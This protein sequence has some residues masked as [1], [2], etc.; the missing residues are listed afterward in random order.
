MIQ[1]AW[2]IVLV[3]TGT[4]A[5]LL[6]YVVSADWIFFGLAAKLVGGD[7]VH[8]DATLI[9][10]DVSWNSLAVQ[11]ADAVGEANDAPPDDPGDPP[12]PSGK[13]PGKTVKS[14]KTAKP[15]KGKKLSRTDPDARM[16]TNK[17]NQRLEPSFKQL[18]GVD[19]RCGIN[20]DV[21][22]VRAD[23][24]EGA[25]LHGQIERVEALTG[26]EVETVTADMAYGS[27]ANF[28]TA[29]A[30]GLYTVIPTQRTRPARVPLSRFRYDA[31]HDVLRA[32]RTQRGRPGMVQRRLDGASFR[33]GSENMEAGKHSDEPVQT[34]FGW[35]VILLE[36][37]RTMEPPTFES[38]K[39]QLAQQAQR[40][41]LTAYLQELRE[42]A[43]IEIK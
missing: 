1:A 32:F 10:A 13:A 6:D 11:Y 31:K 8:V 21:A 4:Y 18:T 33:R 16:A 38:V 34:Q 19:S 20:V 41:A 24:H 12:P 9:R 22:V 43:E 42:S 27:A 23:I 39:P 5:Q 30:R 29:E 17:Y 36:E 15:K 3:A 40:A 35:H 2:A 25:T 28:A 37:V 14:G 26:L 7:M